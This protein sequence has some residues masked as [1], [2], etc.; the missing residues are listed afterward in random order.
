M[1]NWNDDWRDEKIEEANPWYSEQKS[2]TLPFE[3]E[4]V[5]RMTPKE[6]QRRKFKQTTLVLLFASFIVGFGQKL[7]E[8]FLKE[9]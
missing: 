9:S 5:E 8:H 4:K 3:E 2:E 6:V 1:S 7:F